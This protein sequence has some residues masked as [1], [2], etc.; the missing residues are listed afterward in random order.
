MHPPRHA[1]FAA[2]S[3]CTVKVASPI[4]LPLVAEMVTVP[5]PTP[6]AAPEELIVAKE[7][8]DESHETWRVMSIA[9]P[10]L[11]CPVAVKFWVAP[12][13]IDALDGRIVMDVRVAF[14]T[15]SVAVPT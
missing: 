4:T 13:A 5:A 8:L 7:L 11:K 6:N 9:L 10:S 3:Y 12:S 14:V 1:R 15:V 2:T